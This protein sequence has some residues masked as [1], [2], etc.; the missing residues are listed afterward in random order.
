MQE[1]EKKARIAVRYIIK[2]DIFLIL[3]WWKSYIMIIYNSHLLD[4]IKN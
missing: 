2:Q 4:K 3:F 1:I